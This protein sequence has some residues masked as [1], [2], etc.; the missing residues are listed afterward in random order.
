MS[1]GIRFRT[2]KQPLYI[3]TYVWSTGS[4]KTFAKSKINHYGVPKTYDK[5]IQPSKEMGTMEEG[6]LEGYLAIDF[7]SEGAIWKMNCS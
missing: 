4:L 1:Y 7:S 2:I 6:F 5:Q 3:H